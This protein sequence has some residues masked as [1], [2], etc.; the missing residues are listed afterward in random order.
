MSV[1]VV[2]PRAGLTMVEGTIM[3]WMV[4]EGAMVNKGQVIMGYENEKSTIDYEALDSGWIH[5]LTPAG[6]TV[7]VGSP[8]AVLASDE[9]EYKRLCHASS[10]E[11]AA[12]EEKGCARECPTC[13]HGTQSSLEVSAVS[14]LEAAAAAEKDFGGRIVAT[15]LAKRMAAE[16]NVDL[17]LVRPTGGPTGRRIVA[18]D[19]EAYLQAQKTDLP[20]S[21]QPLLDEVEKIPWVGVRK[22][23]A[24]NMFNSMQQSA[25]CTCTCEVNATRLLELR[26]RLVEGQEVLGCKITVNDLLCKMLGKILIK[27][28]FANGTFDGEALLSYQHVHLSV[29]VGTE[30]GLM[31][32]VVKFADQL[33]LTEISR[34]VKDLAARAKS[35]TL[36]PDEQSGGTFTITNVGMYPIDLGTPVL[37]P[38]QVAIC[39]FGRTVKKPVVLPDDSVAVQSMM[40]VFLTFDHRV[41]DG[42]E[43]GKILKD[44][45]TY[46]EHPE[47]ILA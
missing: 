10:T 2:M 38:P 36:A 22:I 18:K 47:L 42:L 7:A 13:V 1:E 3:E 27:H 14:A 9:E 17:R 20:V 23:I 21:E 46:V 35:K 40:N 45:Q 30:D 32:P 15:G 26:A 4:E 19:V 16:A 25:Q 41:I 12:E 39:G 28:P 33:S 43:V 29:A 34:K 24:R 11:A 31:V 37:N 6:E 8:I 5:I 44:I